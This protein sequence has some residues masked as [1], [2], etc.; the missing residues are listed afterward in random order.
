MT[1]ER[2]QQIQDL[3]HAAL[4][5]AIPDRAALLAQADPELRREVESL[6]VQNGGPIME[7]PAMEVAADLLASGQLNAGTQI[8]PY[9]IEGLLGAGGMGRVYKARDTR[10]GRSVAIK[11]ASARFGERFQREAR[12]ISA[13]NHPNICT[14]HDVGPNYLVME[15]V[16]GPTLADRIKK[17]PIP[18][19]EALA[20]ARQIADGLAAAHDQGVVHRDLKPANVKIR[21]DGAVKVLDFGLAK[22]SRDREGAADASTL[23]ITEAG[24]IM[25]TTAYMAPEQARGEEVDKRADIWAFGVVLYEMLTGRR[26]FQGDSTTEVLASV[27]KEEPDLTVAPRKVRRL[28]AEC[29]EKDPRRRLRDIGD[30]WRLLDSV[31]ESSARAKSPPHLVW[32]IA[33]AALL[34]ALGAALFAPS[35]QRLA[36]TDKAE[37]AADRE[38]FVN[39]VRK[40]DASAIAAQFTEDAIYLGSIGMLGSALNR[41]LRG[42]AE[43]EKYFKTTTG[44]P[45]PRAALGTDADYSVTPIE[46]FGGGRA[47]V[48]G[49]NVHGECAER[50]STYTASG[51]ICLDPQETARWLLETGC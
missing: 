50:R 4:E 2:L 36:D 11:I 17:G 10:L 25:G 33:A 37:I 44:L 14:L 32:W 18:L 19:E 8:G 35:R 12:A 51:P 13:L 3:Y 40:G 15:L 9:R 24:T 46:I 42:R 41:V 49:W 23:T 28:I 20:V 43:I 7:R 30:G 39:A 26:L 5:R 31:A 22:Q 27:L 16:E 38:A 34:I 48:R 45:G 1:S 47:R 21:P 29:L 6:L